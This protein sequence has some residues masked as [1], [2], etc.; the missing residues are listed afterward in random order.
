MVVTQPN[1]W[2][3][4]WA[5]TLD[6]EDVAGVALDLFN[7]RAQEGASSDDSGEGGVVVEAVRPCGGTSGLVRGE[8][9][10]VCH[11]SCVKWICPDPGPAI[12]GCLVVRYFIIG[13]SRCHS[14]E[15]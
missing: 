11:G 8:Q 4:A 15:G 6:P 5:E 7:K 2:T 3:F 13:M 10:T 14:A 12:H 9:C 1:F